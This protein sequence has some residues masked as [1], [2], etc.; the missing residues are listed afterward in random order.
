MRLFW[1]KNRFC[2]KLNIKQLAFAQALVVRYDNVNDTGFEE[3]KTNIIY[4]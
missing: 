1:P 2:E 4:T 3:L